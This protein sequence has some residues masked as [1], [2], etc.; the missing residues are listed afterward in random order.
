MDV[1]TDFAGQ[2]GFLGIQLIDPFGQVNYG[3]LQMGMDPAGTTDP[4]I[5]VDYVVYESTPNAP[6]TV[7]PVPE[8]GTA[9]LMSLGMVGLAIRRRRQVRT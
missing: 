7:A 4:A 6:I 1:A 3:Y 5:H 9:A 8:P 2:Y